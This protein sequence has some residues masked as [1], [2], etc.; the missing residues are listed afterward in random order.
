MMSIV[1]VPQLKIIG[2]IALANQLDPNGSFYSL[3]QDL[4]DDPQ[5]AQVDQQLQEQVGQTNRVGLVVYAPESYLYWAGVAVPATFSTPQ[6]WQ[7]YLL[8]A[9]QAFEV[10]QATPEFMPQI[11]LNFKLDQ[12]FVQAE[13]E[14]VQLPDS[15]GHAQQPYFLEEL[16]FN[17]I[18]HVDQQRYLVYLS[19]EIEALEDDL[20]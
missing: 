5:M 14:N 13:K 17:D 9:G 1:K 20:G 8:P 19:D 15:L 7:S 18:N 2:R 10:T 6:G 16:K 4:N 12:I 3:W 11:P